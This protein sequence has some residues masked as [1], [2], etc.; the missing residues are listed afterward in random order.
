MRVWFLRL[1]E[2]TAV[3]G[4]DGSKEEITREELAKREVPYTYVVRHWNMSIYVSRSIHRAIARKLVE[5]TQ[6]PPLPTQEQWSDWLRP[7][8]TTMHIEFT[9]RDCVAR[10]KMFNRYAR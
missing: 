2:E 7:L 10:C 8:S 3:Y 9:C 5:E 4:A 1:G 6:T